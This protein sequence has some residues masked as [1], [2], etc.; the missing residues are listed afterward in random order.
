M[1]IGR[2]RGSGG[3]YI[4]KYRAGQ[5]T[6]IPKSYFLPRTSAVR[7]TPIFVGGWQGGHHHCCCGGGVSGFGR[8]LAGFTAFM[9]VFSGFFGGLF[10]RRDTQPTDD[11]AALFGAAGY[12]DGLNGR[13]YNPFGLYRTPSAE[14]DSAAQGADSQGQ[15]V[16]KSNELIDL[17][18]DLND[19]YDFSF[20]EGECPKLSDDGQ[21]YTYDGKEFDTI[22]K[23]RNYIE[24][25][26]SPKA[27]TAA[28]PAVAASVSGDDDQTDVEEEGG[29]GDDTAVSNTN[30]KK[31]SDPETKPDD[32]TDYTNSYNN[33][34]GF[35]YKDGKVKILDQN[36]P[37]IV[38]W[39]AFVLNDNEN[40]TIRLEK[41]DWKNDFELVFGKDK[42]ISEAEFTKWF[43][44]YAKEAKERSNE[45]NTKRKDVGTVNITD[46][47]KEFIRNL[48]KAMS[49]NGKTLSARQFKTFME[50]FFKENSKSS[51]SRKEFANYVQKKLEAQKSSDSEE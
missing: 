9:G 50:G 14:S 27:K 38:T 39:S 30:T 16:S 47:D 18:S 15:I 26:N 21:K 43:E 32:K 1:A 44:N 41:K 11:S 51:F 35:S 23:L 6:N 13:S 8:F 45:P 12:N 4:Q 24:D 28:A 37:E 42:E 31:E 19:D 5:R 17:I 33:K 29:G 10:G 34:N 2:Y 48:Y 25:K 3:A 20:P 36:V 22:T 49:N 7:N 46:T 40:S